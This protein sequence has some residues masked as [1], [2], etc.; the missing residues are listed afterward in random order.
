MDFKSFGICFVI[1]PSHRCII[2]VWCECLRLICLF[3]G[4]S[5]WVFRHCS[6]TIYFL[7]LQLFYWPFV[8]IR[9]YSDTVFFFT[10]QMFCRLLISRRF[11]CDCIWILSVSLFEFEPAF[12]FRLNF[13]L[14][15]IWI[16]FARYLPSPKRKGTTESQQQHKC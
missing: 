9:H 14:I 11:L 12:E 4:G 2:R 15:Y 10:L 5:D 8:T 6:H 13:N 3:F 1:F 7:T 16:W